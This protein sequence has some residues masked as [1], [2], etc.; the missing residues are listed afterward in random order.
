NF[1][2]SVGISLS[3]PIFNGWQA[4]ANYERSK[5]NIKTLEYQRNLDNQTLKQDIYQAYNSVIVALEKFNSSAKSIDAAQRTYDF[6][7][8]R[9]NIGMLGTFELVTDQNNLFRAKLQYVLNQFDYVF[10][11]KVLEFYKGQGLKLAP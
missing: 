3:V 7:L 1:G 2:Q 11:M 10:K 8:K 5:L 9:F 4:K 6:A